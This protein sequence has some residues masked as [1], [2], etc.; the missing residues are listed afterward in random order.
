MSFLAGELGASKTGHLQATLDIKRVS[1]STVHSRGKGWGHC[2]VVNL[3]QLN[4]H[5]PIMSILDIVL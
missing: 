4:Q 1:M 5:I 3:Q 2:P